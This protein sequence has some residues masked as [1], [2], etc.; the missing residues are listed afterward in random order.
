MILDGMCIYHYWF[1]NGKR[2]LEKPAENLLKWRNIQMPFCFYWANQTWAR[3]WKKLNGAC[4]WS[5]TYESKRNHGESGVL[6]KQGYGRE[7]DWEEHFLYLLPF[8]QDERYIKI[9]GRP[10]FVIYQPDDIFS[11]WDMADYFDKR[12]KQ[13]GL[14]GIYFIGSGSGVIQG[15]DATFEKQ[16]DWRTDSYEQM[17][18]MTLNQKINKS[19]R[20]YL[21]GGVDFDNSPRMGKECFIL[22]GASPHKFNKYFKQLYKK[23]QMLNNEFVFINAWNEW[24]EG[25]YLEPDEK[26]GF[27]YLEALK[28]AVIECESENM[29]N[30]KI[31]ISYYTDEEIF[32]KQRL[33]NTT[34]Y[35]KLFEKWLCLKEQNI[36]F[37]VYFEKYGY[38][39]IAVYGIGKIGLHLLN[40]LRNGNIKVCY[41]IDKNNKKIDCEIDVYNPEQQLP[42]VDAIVITVINQYREISEMLRKNMNCSMITV[43]EVIQEL[44]L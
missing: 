21:C 17:W 38:H 39:N 24:G 36:D 18:E 13:S 12:A 1:E 30:D 43:E 7:N 27:G 23:S 37:S 8:F 29:L 22:K 2:I 5:A 14:E 28:Q 9:S 41:G 19:N 15:L 32:L 42:N 44:M 3:T 6:L 35:N 26:Y 25:M 40:E 31:N 20:T 10:V 33:Q 4:V 16:P 34:R 11:L